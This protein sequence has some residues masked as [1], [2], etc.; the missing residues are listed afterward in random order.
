MKNEKVKFPYLFDR[1]PDSSP[2]EVVAQDEND[3]QETPQERVYDQAARIIQRLWRKHVNIA[4]FKYF[5]DLV[6]FGS[7]G[8][9]RNLLKYV[10]PREAEMLDAASGVYVRFRLGG[11]TFPPNVYYKIFT[12]R[13]IV[14]LCASSP[15]DYTHAGQKHLVPMQI[16][17]GQPVV[18]DDHTGWYKRV[19]NNGWRL[20]SGKVCLF[21]DPIFQNTHNKKFEFH[22]CK[23]RR[24]QDVERKKKTRKIEWMKKMYEDGALYACTD[25]RETA[26]LVEHS[27]QGMMRT[28]QEHGP[29]TILDWEVDE[30]IEW[31]NAL[32]FEEYVNEW[33]IVGTSN[34]SALKEDNQAFFSKLDPCK[35]S[36]LTQD[37]C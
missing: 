2:S 13:P 1:T 29:D 9:P 6:N 35:C 5:K 11:T 31:T 15:K 24:Q 34:S 17:N 25:Q 18:H 16:H 27:A 37:S 32:N 3:S 36:Q 12:H 7:H 20:L 14:D 26:E 33:K 10:N 4:V 19:E 28:V 22:H 30:L 23:I 8:D 21:G